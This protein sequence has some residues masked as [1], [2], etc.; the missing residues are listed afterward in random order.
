MCKAT[1]VRSSKP[2][3]E[4]G[5]TPSLRVL[6]RKSSWSRVSALSF[7]ASRSL[8]SRDRRPKFDSANG[9]KF[10]EICSFDLCDGQQYCLP[11]QNVRWKRRLERRPFH[12]LNRSNSSKI[13]PSGNFSEYREYFSVSARLRKPRPQLSIAVG[14]KAV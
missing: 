2:Q 10:E 9:L 1:A 4:Y 13:R 14:I 8:F 7:G 3:E 5:C 12:S 6:D 11:F